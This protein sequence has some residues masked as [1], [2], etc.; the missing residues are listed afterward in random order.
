[1]NRRIGYLVAFFVLLAV[2]ICIGL[3]VRDAF[4]RP[5][6]GDMLVTVLLCCLSRAVFPKLSPAVPAFLLAAAV[7]GAQWLE[8]GKLLGL[9]GTVLGV[10]L[11]ATFDWVDILCYGVGCLLFAAAERMIKHPRPGFELL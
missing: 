8:L 11:G 3:W 10:I 7:E 1:M 5:Y 4:M 9:N 2:E 6:V